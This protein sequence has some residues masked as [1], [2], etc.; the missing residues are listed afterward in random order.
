[1]RRLRTSATS[2]L[3]TI[4]GLFAAGQTLAQSHVPEGYQLTFREEFTALSLD[5]GCTGSGTWATYWCRWNVRYLSGNNDR[6]LKADPSYRGSGGPTLAEH[7]LV[8]HE[9]TSANTL[10]L[11]GHV[12]P[13]AVRPQYGGFPYVG[14]MISSERSH[15]QTYGYWEVRGRL[16]NTSTGHHWAMWL[17]PQDGGWPPE[18]DMVEVV[19]QNPR[20]FH[21]NA[22]GT[23]RNELVWFSPHDPSGWHTWGFLW[24]EDDMV[25]YVDGVERKRI[26]NYVHEP[27]Y[28]LISPEIGSNWPGSPDGTTVWPMEAEID[29]VR[30]YEAGIPSGEDTSAPSVPT[31]VA[32]TALSESE[33]DLTWSPS[34]DDVGFTR[35]E[36]Q[37]GEAFLG[38]TDNTF[39]RDTGLAAGTSYNY[40]VRAC[41]GAENCSAFSS[42]VSATTDD[43]GLLPGDELLQITNVDASSV[44]RCSEVAWTTNQP[45]DALVE[46][47]TQPGALTQS[48]YDI[49]LATEHRLR[50]SALSRKTIY[51]FKVTSV[52]GRGDV[53]TSD[54]HSFRAHSNTR[55]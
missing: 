45:A 46:Y 52:D 9:W 10:K 51:Y 17:N 18:I 11:Y 5:P 40:R 44:G 48:A 23:G 49:M 42:W 26:S 16:T 1:M 39:F 8:T 50:L 7:G 24:T 6:A 27:L 3:A 14:G 15:A 21:M 53:A 20:T 32:A 47:G 30:V 54:V 4:L 31:G 29:Y 12:L 34:T 41:D 38:A 28:W 33:I 36:I 37:R 35:Y 55:C 43:G 13:E 19:G 22:H 2:V 25:W